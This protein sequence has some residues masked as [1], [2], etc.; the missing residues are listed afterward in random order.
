MIPLL[1]QAAPGHA[2]LRGRQPGHL[3]DGGFQRQEVLLAHHR[4]QHIG[5]GAPLA[6]M[7]MRIEGQAVG[8]DHGQGMGEDAV[9]VRR[10]HQ[11][12]DGAGRRQAGEGGF[13]VQP[14]FGHDVAEVA[15]GGLRVALG[16]GD[17]RA[18]GKPR[19]VEPQHGRGRGVGV[20][21]QADGLRGRRAADDVERFAGAAVVA[22]AGQL[23]VREHHA[24]IE[25]AADQQ[26]LFHGGHDVIGLVAQVGGVQAGA[27]RLLGCLQGQA[28]VDD[29]IGGRGAG[30]RV[31][32]AGGYAEGARVQR[33]LQQATHGGAFGVVSGARGVVH[34]GHPQGGVAHQRNHV[35]RGGRAAQRVHPRLECVEAEQ[36]GGAE[37][38]QRL[39]NV[40]ALKR[41]EADAAVAGDDSGN[42]L[43]HLGQHVGMRQQVAVVVGMRVDEAWGQDLA[44]AVDHRHAGRVR[45]AA[46][47]DDPFAQH[48]QVALARGPAGAVDKRGAGH[49]EVC[50]QGAIRHCLVQFFDAGGVDDLLPL[51]GFT[52]DQLLEVLGRA[53]GRHGA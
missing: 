33:F 52:I 5:E 46:Y 36:L 19:A 51:G 32:G 26:R 2:V 50:L 53:R 27:A 14:Q 45:K 22:F 39:R 31:E 49:D 7:R 30:G 17:H 44:P 34:D 4:A 18:A 23:V 3:V 42:A 24:A 1:E 38:V 25:F 37:Q 43:R 48:G 20:A 10:V 28:N 41:R 16:P 12:I 29:F 35:D 21:V 47:R 8:P 9:D 15:A 40:V 11:E 6:G 13:V